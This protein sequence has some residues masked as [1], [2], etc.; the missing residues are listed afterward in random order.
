VFV[1]INSKG[2]PLNQAD[3]I[4]TLMSVWWDEGRAQL[5]AFSRAGRQPSTTGPSP[6]N[7]FIK[8]DPDQLLRVA[9][10]LGFRRGQLRAVYAL[11][12]GRD[13]STEDGQ[14]SDERRE[15]QFK[16]LREAQSYALDLTNWHEFLK[17]LIRA[18]FRSESMITS[19]NALLYAYVVY[20]VGKRDFKVDPH[21]LREVMARWF[22][23]TSLTGRYTSSPE[24]R[25]ESDLALLRGL[26]TADEFIEV[27]DGVIEQ[28]LTNDFW[29]ITLPNALATSAARSPSLYGYY[30]ALNLL[31]AKVLFSRL[32][33]NELF[34]PALKAKKSAVERH[35]LFP[36]VYLKSIGIEALKDVN[37]IA[38]FALVEWP[39]NAAISGAP[40][41]EY[42]Q[43]YAA[44]ETNG[45][46]AS[47]RFW[48]ALP[49]GWE[50]MAYQ[51]FLA[52]R[53]VELAK[54][55]R[56]GFDWL[57]HG[58]QVTDKADPAALIAQGESDSVEFKSSARYNS[59]T[60]ERDPKIELVIVKTVAGFANG[61]G[62][63]LLIGVNDQGEIVGLENDL[64]LVKQGDL[65]RYQL[66]LT[67]LLEKTIG[68]PA[69]TAASVDF[70]DVAGVCI[71][72][73]VVES[74]PTPVF[75]NPPGG[76][77]QADFY[78]RM[79]NSTRQMTTDEV[80][81]YQA[82]RWAGA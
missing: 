26:T 57:R 55:I 60:K 37:Q 78:V 53:R 81:A 9:V 13:V 48:H 32:R 44:R 27:L 79:G 25:V 82:V 31:D 6:F 77:K 33:V 76:E 59:H 56:A 21:T 2:V 17:V 39:D 80:L 28:A 51:E 24:S 35:H 67:D 1:R 62:G 12:R 49:T 65:D 8:P 71:C 36:R 40:P 16:V 50:H 66:W 3:F 7:H 45:D 75:V 20:L 58:E 15:A 34:D 42:F 30:A 23:M 43:K 68:K 47:M 14:P 69:T 11:L 10:G 63:T 41:S 73:V 54:V 72:R 18:G 74:A 38:N 64:A 5:E 61:K 46:L 52:A 22:F 70:P 29:R 4:L 19:S